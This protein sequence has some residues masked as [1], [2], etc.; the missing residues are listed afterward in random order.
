ME[1]WHE[2]CREMELYIRVACMSYQARTAHMLLLLSVYI[3]IY[4]YL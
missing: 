2:Y 4:L 3:M 1:H